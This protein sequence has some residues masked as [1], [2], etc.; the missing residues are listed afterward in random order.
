MRALLPA[1]IVAFL[2]LAV[3][4]LCV[5]MIRRNLA[6]PLAGG[7]TATIHPASFWASLRESKCSISYR[8]HGR[9]PG[10]VTLLETRVEWPIILIPGVGTE[11][12][13]VPV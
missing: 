2:G 3:A 7:E 12:T 10:T 6:V 5:G 1:T 13:P 8:P 4:A 9:R 11:H